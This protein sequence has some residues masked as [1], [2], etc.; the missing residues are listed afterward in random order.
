MEAQE[1]ETG[2]GFFSMF[3]PKRDVCSFHCSNPSS[4]SIAVFL[5]YSVQKSSEYNCIINRRNYCK[6]TGVDMTCLPPVLVWDLSFGL[7]TVV[8]IISAYIFFFPGIIHNRI[9]NL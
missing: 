6:V 3:L 7:L 1:P 8:V 2:L 5:Q 4:D 9:G